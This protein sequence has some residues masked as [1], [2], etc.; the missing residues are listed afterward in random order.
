MGAFHAEYNTVKPR[1]D[2]SGQQDAT[3][4]IIITYGGSTTM[5]TTSCAQGDKEVRKR[6][7]YARIHERRA[8]N[9]GPLSHNVQP[10][11]P[12]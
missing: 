10:L 6:A 2:Y 9:N 4:A 8:L 3:G 12:G 5:L 11:M 7:F 1:H